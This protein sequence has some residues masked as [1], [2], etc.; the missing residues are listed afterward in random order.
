M[1]NNIY[2]VYCDMDGVIVN[3]IDPMLSLIN[4]PNNQQTQEGQKAI[5]RFKRNQFIRDDLKDFYKAPK[6]IID[7]VRLFSTNNISF[8]ENLEWTLDGKELWDFL[9]PYNPYILSA[10][11]DKDSIIG[12]QMWVLQNLRIPSN[13]VILTRDKENYANPYS[14]LIDDTSKNIELFKKHKGI[15]ILHNNTQETIKILKTILS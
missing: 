7:Y 1:K 3:F 10:P 6:E 5:A 11:T 8:W 15:G 2:K 9:K 13:R 14:I 12:K 4:D